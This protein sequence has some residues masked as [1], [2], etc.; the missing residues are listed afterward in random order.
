[1]EMFWSMACRGVELTFKEKSSR[2]GIV[3]CRARAKM[4]WGYVIALS[5]RNFPR[6]EKI[7]HTSSRI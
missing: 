6:V 2:C 3:D 4:Q 7:I 5:E 1:M